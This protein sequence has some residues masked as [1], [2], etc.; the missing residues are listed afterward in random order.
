MRL[1]DPTSLITV[2]VISVVT[3]ER[4]ADA[5]PLAKALLAGGLPVSEITLRTP[6]A[7]DAVR[8][9]VAEVPDVF[10]GVGVG[11]GT[12]T[13][14]SEV[15]RAVEAGADFL[16]SPGTPAGL[17]QAL[18]EAPIPA[19]PGCA[20][21]SEAMT[22]A[23]LGFPVLKFFPA[24][25]S[26]GVRWL[27]AVAEPLPHIRFCPTGGVNGDNA[28]SYLALP[29]VIAVGGSWVAPAQAIAAGDF[30][31]IVERARAAAGLRK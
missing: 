26:G 29:N 15:A 7:I 24:E 2:P 21:V 30:A 27:R 14:P 28:A 12:V 18:I 16:V 23:A 31:G 20:T 8:A 11:V 1:S 9:M 22:L 17:A 5:I 4:V 13:A 10:V 25:P 6:A 19:L 3:I